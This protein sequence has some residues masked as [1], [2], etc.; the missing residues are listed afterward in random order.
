MKQVK[1]TVHKTQG[2]L[3]AKPIDG[4]LVCR[5]YDLQVPG[6]EILPEEPVDD[7]QGIGDPVFIKLTIHLLIGAI[8][9]GPKP[10]GSYS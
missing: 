4:R 8:Q 9:L 6:T 5:F 10:L 1:Q 2:L 3:I 7:H